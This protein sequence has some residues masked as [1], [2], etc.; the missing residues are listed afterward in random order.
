MKLRKGDVLLLQYPLKK[1]YD[2]IV[3][4]AVKHGVK[5]VTLIHDLGSFR[6]KKLTVDEEISRLNRSHILMVHTNEMAEWLRCHGIT[7]PI[8]E[9]GLWDY[10]SDAPFPDEIEKNIGEKVT[11][12]Y[13][14]DLRPKSNNWI[15][16]LVREDS[17]LRLRLYGDGFNS[18][19]KTPEITWEGFA[20]SNKLASLCDGDFG[21]VWYEDSLDDITGPIGQYL[22]YCAS[23]KASLYLRAGIPIV[24]WEKA[25]LAR[26]LTQMGVAVAVPSLRDI[27]QRI[28]S[29][30]AE[31]YQDM[32]RK[33][34]EIGKK[35]SEG[36]YLSRALKKAMAN[37]GG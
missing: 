20:D 11:L 28:K 2:F 3:K 17:D 21:V 37:I 35:I 30:S 23:H 7:V 14:G 5:V 29:L 31:E 25:A 33:A 26:T 32:R 12:V 10:I 36:V 6:R 9:I 19:D 15:Y 13:A 24:I 4:K 16:E 34:Q 27:S 18:A 8:I 1:Y 22:P